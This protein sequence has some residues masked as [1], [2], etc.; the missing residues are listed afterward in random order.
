MDPQPDALDLRNQFAATLHNWLTR[1]HVAEIMK[2]FDK[3]FTPEPP[4]P[5][6]REGVAVATVLERILRDGEPGGYQSYIEAELEAVKGALLGAPRP[7]ESSEPEHKPILTGNLHGSPET[8]SP[9]EAPQEG[10]K[11]KLEPQE[12]P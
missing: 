3:I 6:L 7:A 11:S 8:G 5:D 12:K 1:S 2:D 10:E 4:A 9:G